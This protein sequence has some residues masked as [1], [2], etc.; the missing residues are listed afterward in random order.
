MKFRSAPE[1]DQHR[2]VLMSNF[3]AH[4]YIGK[5]RYAKIIKNCRGKRAG[6]DAKIVLEEE[7]EEMRVL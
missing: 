3:E 1:D 4:C 5:G 2:S 6:E 7:E